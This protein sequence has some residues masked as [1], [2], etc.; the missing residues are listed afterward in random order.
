MKETILKGGSLATTA[1]VDDGEKKFVRKKISIAK[2]RE[3]GYYRWYSQL[4]KMQRLGRMYPGMFVK[5]IDFGYEER[6][7]RFRSHE[8][9][10]YMDLEY[11]PDAVNCY[12]YLCEKRTDNEVIN[13]FNKII[14][15]LNML[16]VVR[17]PSFSNSMNLYFQEE[18]INKLTDAT[19]THMGFN[20]LLHEESNITHMLKPMRE[21][22]IKLYVDPFESW[23]HGNVTLE[24]ILY[25]RDSD[26]V[27]FIDPYEENVIDN[28]LNEYS[29]LMQSSNSHYELMVQHGDKFEVPEGIKNFN[30]VLKG[31][32]NKHLTNTERMLVKFFEASQYYRMLPFKLKANRNIDAVRPFL[33]TAERLTQEFLR[34]S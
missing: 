30:I 6:H 29:Q 2:E 23:T 13:L 18:I 32:L 19:A 12:E 28:K 14:W 17:I 22:A 7:V 25:L 5:V 26:E 8:S 4:K 10:A 33:E 16:H 1:I 31:H 20:H 24:N 21:K 15:K 27:L 11:H 3:Y 34:A 9:Y